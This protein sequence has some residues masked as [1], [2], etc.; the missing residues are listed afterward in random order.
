M[1]PAFLTSVS[2][3][4]KE[5]DPASLTNAQLAALAALA[6]QIEWTLQEREIAAQ[7]E[8]AEFDAMVEEFEA[9]EFRA[10]AFASD[11]ED[12]FLDSVMES[13]TEIEL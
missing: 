5:L 1:A 3:S 12:F 11:R 4:V 13:R 8:A 6:Q 9:D 7:R 2:E 10:L